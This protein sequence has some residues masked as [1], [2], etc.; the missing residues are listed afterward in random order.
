MKN[1]A[2]IPAYVL[3]LCCGILAW[4]LPYYLYGL[5]QP[6]DGAL[7]YFQDRAIRIYCLLLICGGLV[8]ASS[9]QVRL[10]ILV[11]VLLLELVVGQLIGRSISQATFVGDPPI[12][13][14]WLV[15][16]VYSIGFTAPSALLTR[17]MIFFVRSQVDCKLQENGS[18]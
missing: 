5:R 12:A 16:L 7:P 10:R 3:P 2:I 17:F 9:T 15:P 6:W 4:W 18:S 14:A 11:P 8:G 1:I 13:P